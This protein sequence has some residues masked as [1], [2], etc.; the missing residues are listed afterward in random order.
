MNLSTQLIEKPECMV[1]KDI[2][3]P[4]V[5]V[6][7]GIREL[8]DVLSG[9]KS[10]EMTLID[11]NSGLI[12]KIAHQLCVHTYRMF[13]GNVVYIDGGMCVDPYKMS[14]YARLMEM[15]QREVLEH[16]LVSRSFTVYQLTTLI[17]ERL[18]HI[19]VQY[20]PKVLIGG[21]FPMLYFDSDVPTKEAQVLLR[22]NLQKIKELTTRYGLVTVFTNA[23][24]SGLSNG[25]NIRN[26]LSDSVDEL[27]LMRE[28]EFVTRV[29]VMKK[30]VSTMIPHLSRGQ[31]RL[32]DFG[33]VM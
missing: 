8:D 33:L 16:I 17:Q 3:K 24:S 22:S 1:S 13:H 21:C 19:I 26:I 29:E 27:V 15:N 9:F 6:I 31:L 23:G 10:G 20:A 28:H 5:V 30:G 2:L 32:C 14:Q 12:P 7:S 25:R 4:S 11:G 18:E